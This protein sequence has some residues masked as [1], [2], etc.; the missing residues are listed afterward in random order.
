MSDPA[1]CR[2][3]EPVF[4][5]P[6]GLKGTA[7]SACPMPNSL[8]GFSG[9]PRTVGLKELW[10]RA[11]G[12]GPNTAPW[13]TLVRAASGGVETLPRQALGKWWRPPQLLVAFTLPAPP[14]APASGLP[15]HKTS[16]TWPSAS[17]GP[18]PAFPSRGDL[19][20]S[21]Q[22]GL[23]GSHLA[24]AQPPGGTPALR[25]LQPPSQQPGTLPPCSPVPLQRH[26]MCGAGR[27]PCRPVPA[28]GQRVT[29]WLS[30]EDRGPEKA[31]DND[32]HPPQI[33]VPVVLLCRVCWGWQGT[34]GA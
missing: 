12:L 34:M 4:P 17:G 22:P 5:N 13:V 27:D 26:P 2:V 31:P 25:A 20:H 3:P 14:W 19:G 6:R 21:P 32:H 10:L 15:G 8:P 18:Q 7:N 24:T 33:G 9:S 30:T 29:S 16:A 1:L 11:S 23:T 28:S